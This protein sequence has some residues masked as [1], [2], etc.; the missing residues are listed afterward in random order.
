MSW[1][2]NPGDSS[3]MSKHNTNS[4]SNSNKHNTAIIDIG[5]VLASY[6]NSIKSNINILSL[7]A[8]DT[9]YVLNVSHSGWLDIIVI[10]HSNKIVRGWFP[11]N[12]VRFYNDHKTRNIHF[13]KL[14][15]LLTGANSS[16][17]SS[18]SSASS[19]PLSEEDE[20]EMEDESLPV[21][22]SIQ[23][24]MSNHS[25]SWESISNNTQTNKNNNN[26]NQNKLNNNTTFQ[27]SKLY[28]KE[29]IEQDYY[30][31][32]FNNNSSKKPIIW[33]VILNKDQKP[34]NNNN[35]KS[36]LYYYNQEF[37]IHCENLPKLIDSSLQ[38]QKLNDISNLKDHKPFLAD[39]N[40]FYHDENDIISITNLFENVLYSTALLKD[41]IISTRNKLKLS[42]IIRSIS[43][44]VTYILLTTRQFEPYFLSSTKKQIRTLLKSILKS[45]SLINLN[46]NIHYSNNSITHENYNPLQ[47][48]IIS[49]T[50]FL[51]NDS[52]RNNSIDTTTS[53]NTLKQQYHH[54]QHNNIAYSNN[55][56]VTSISS[57]F[58]KNSTIDNSP[59]NDSMT[60][61]NMDILQRIDNL[62]FKHIES[63]QVSIQLLFYNIQNCVNLSNNEDNKLTLPQILPR[64]F[65]ESYGNGSW[66]NCFMDPISSN[67]SDHLSPHLSNG[68]LYSKYST[69]SL[70][71]T[72]SD[73][74]TVTT[75]LLSPMTSRFINEQTIQENIEKFMSPINSN[76]HGLT[77]NTAKN[78]STATTTTTPKST[79]VN[80][81]TSVT[82]TT[83]TTTSSS[84]NHSTTKQ[85][86][87]RSI[88]SANIAKITTSSVV[89]KNTKTKYNNRRYPLNR[90]TLRIMK[91]RKDSLYQGM[92]DY[93]NATT[94][95]TKADSKEILKI[96]TELHDQTV[97]MYVIE[98]L[99]LSFFHNLRNVID[100]GDP[101]DETT[102]LLNH[103]SSNIMVLLNNYFEIKQAFYDAAIDLTLAT[104]EVTLDDPKVFHSMLPFQCVGSMERFQI[105][106]DVYFRDGFKDDKYTCQAD[107]FAKSLYKQLTKEDTD[108]DDYGFVNTHDKFKLSYSKY[109]DI[110]CS[111]YSVVE[112]LLEEKE[113]IVNFA[114]RTMQDKL[115]SE[116]QKNE[117]KDA[118]WFE[119]DFSKED[120]AKPVDL[121]E[122]TSNNEFLPWYLQTEYQESIIFDPITK[123]IKFGTKEG[124]VSYLIYG[125]SDG[126]LDIKFMDVF[127]LTFKSMYPSTTDMVSAIIAMY[128]LVPP[129]GLTFN[130]YNEWMEKKLSLIKINV[131]RVLRE[132][133]KNYW[134]ITYWE[135]ELEALLFEFANLAKADEIDGAIELFKEIDLLVRH[136]MKAILHDPVEAL[137][138]SNNTSSSQRSGKSLRLANIA[139]AQFAQQVTLINHEVYCKIN[140]FECLDRIWGKQKSCDFGG[141]PSIGKFIEHANLLTNYVSYKIVSQTDIKK[142]VKLIHY[143]ITVAL[144]CQRLSNFASLTAIISAL[145]SSP[146]HRLHKT[147]SQI[148][149]DSKEIL[150]KLDNLMDSKKNFI[151]YRDCLR[152]TPKMIACVPFFGVYLSDLTFANSGNQ[153]SPEM[154][155]FRK[156]VMI[157]DI[158]KDI[159]SFQNRTYITVL[160]KNNDVKMF[161]L[162]SLQGIPDIDK[163][164]ELSLEVEPRGSSSSEERRKSLGNNK[165]WRRKHGIKFF[166]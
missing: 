37:N 149:K 56:R 62:M 86:T 68:R 106:D 111:S 166:G 12:Y 20:L 138:I 84:S 63:L 103:I 76:N 33:Q 27:H 23:M 9:V 120:I 15:T 99:D 100:N 3:D 113:R 163:Q 118:R 98:N 39:N 153:D 53:N 17:S 75:N 60:Y 55:N 48:R 80:S 7:K 165:F 1:K 131:V 16:S 132:F 72:L 127:L 71:S 81:R 67:K 4:N 135:P 61:F 30:N 8:K 46:S 144:Y 116:L 58:S 155:N 161:I 148:S 19:S 45:S 160:A 14:M 42:K 59:R 141:S 147:W 137:N 18:N 92:T 88:S 69:T 110:N 54:H 32:K 70:A 156:R 57:T 82:P 6:R 79:P 38:S 29:Q 10:D 162:D 97:N 87:N 122:V 140:I 26:N 51:T 133:F 134:I 52:N 41:I 25:S 34:H 108:I 152:S 78:T 73:G 104:Q 143:F 35:N 119:S 114:A 164:Y 130:E 128:H 36:L 83:T 154:I 96:Y 2:G 95:N 145:Y 102:K 136:S 107:S 150:Q 112:K 13:N 139:A 91:N 24:E 105:N 44:G 158:I 129:D 101:N 31:G 77:T 117:F 90:D 47:D 124:L 64:F 157:H 142:R 66:S 121:T 115:I 40:L 159:Q 11:Q 43:L 93:M 22:N 94:T 89:S 146:V 5:Y 109:Y 49:T 21:F 28:S 126:S 74:S 123:N 125:H 65:G 50:S 85:P 151:N